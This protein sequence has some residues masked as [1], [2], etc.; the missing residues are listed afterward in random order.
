M[1]LSIHDLFVVAFIPALLLVVWLGFVV[2]PTNAQAREM[3]L[4]PLRPDAPH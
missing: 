1:A 3:R 2:V 4:P